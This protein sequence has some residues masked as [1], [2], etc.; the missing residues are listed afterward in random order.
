M[1]RRSTAGRGRK[2]AVKCGKRVISTHRLKRAANRVKKGRK[3]CRIVKAHAGVRSSRRGLRAG[4]RR[5]G[6]RR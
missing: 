5:R 6:R 4:Q 1:A 2:W 3:G